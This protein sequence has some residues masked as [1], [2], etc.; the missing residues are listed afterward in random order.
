MDVSNIATVKMIQNIIDGTTP[1][2]T[3]GNAT[4]AA[5]ATKATQDGNGNV[6]SE[7]YSLKQ[8]SSGGYAGGSNAS[9]TTGGA[10]GNGARADGGGAIGNGAQAGLGG[11]IGDT[12]TATSGGA[13]GANSYATT[14][15]AVGLSTYATTGFAG[16]ENA[17]A[18]AS[19]S[20]QLGE[21][22]NSTA[23]TFQFRSYQICDASGNIPADRLAN[24]LDIIYPVGSIYMNYSN[25]SSPASKV[26]GTWVQIAT[27]QFLLASGNGY[28]LGATGGAK[29][30]TLT[31][32][33]MPAHGH[34]I[35]NTNNGSNG[36]AYVAQ[37]GTNLWGSADGT[38]SGWGAVNAGALRNTG[39]D[40]PHN[41]MPPYRVVSMW[42][43]TA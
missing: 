39:G 26:G 5:S 13:I 35:Y 25:S 31:T 37:N 16:G 17:T 12:A 40:E 34:E 38:F 15:G 7:T 27:G 42:R 2:T 9:A 1:P 19:G 6:I 3:A 4:T 29:E 21:G 24:V 41:N 43:R 30:V 23:N 32:A 36:G 11:A 18:T 8:N 33:Q 20:V 22:V 10:I 28:S 14:G